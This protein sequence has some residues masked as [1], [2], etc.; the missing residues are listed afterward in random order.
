MAGGLRHQT[1]CQDLDI[2]RIP[3]RAP[4][5]VSFGSEG[6]SDAAP[7]Q[8]QSSKL[9]DPDKGRVLACVEF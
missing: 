4:R 2:P 8:P 7:T 9:Q 1:I 5:L 3:R 6:R